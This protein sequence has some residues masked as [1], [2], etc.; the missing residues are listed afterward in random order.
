[1]VEITFEG[2]RREFR[3][4]DTVEKHNVVVL[5]MV[6]DGTSTFFME[7]QEFWFGES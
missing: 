4:T 5:E 6:K 1:M 7:N 3:F 2:N